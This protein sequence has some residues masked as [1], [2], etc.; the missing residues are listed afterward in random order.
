[1]YVARI[2]SEMRAETLAERLENVQWAVRP[3]T[4]NPQSSKLG[5]DL[6]IRVGEIAEDEVVDAAKKLRE[7]GAG[8]R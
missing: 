5:L 6:P 2:A 1:M 3:S 7:K 8:H 4:L